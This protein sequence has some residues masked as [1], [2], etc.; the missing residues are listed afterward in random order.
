M[1]ALVRRALGA[2]LAYGASSALL[3]QS[4]PT[5]PSPA[6]PAAPAGALSVVG[7]RAARDLAR[8][9]AL[10][11]SD[12]AGDSAAADSLT[13][14]VA[15]RR[16]RAGEPLRY[17]AI[18]RPALVVAGADV[19]VVS[20]VDGVSITRS[21][22]AL[23]GGARGERIRVRLEGTRILVATVTGPSEATIP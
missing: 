17:P 20:S 16:L 7:P 14:W 4:P 11:R 3:A 22:T 8:D 13:G 6:L 15:R 21:G 12:I 23:S 19:T 2:L 18:G 1:S 9:Q 10:L 5:T